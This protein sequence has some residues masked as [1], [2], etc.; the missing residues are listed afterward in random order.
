MKIGYQKND[1]FYTSLALKINAY[2]EQNGISKYANTRMVLK[3][4]FIATLFI[5][6]Y[7]LM[8]SN[9]FKN[10]SLFGLQILFHFSMFLMAVGIAHDGSHYAYSQKRWV[11]RTL[12]YVFDVIGINSHFWTYNHVHSHHAAPNVPILDSAIESF[13]AVRLHPKTKLN[14]LNKYQHL[15]MFLIYAFVPLFQIFLLEFVSFAKKVTGY[16]EKDNHSRGQIYFMC[17]SKIVF[18]SYSLIILLVV[19]HAPALH[20]VIGFLVGNMFIGILL[21]IIFQTTHICTHSIFPDPDE[22]GI[23]ETTYSKHIFLTTSEFAVENPLVTWI[24]GGLNLHATHHLFPHVSHIH[25]PAM[26]RIVRETAKEYNMP[27][28]SY[29]FWGAIFSHLKTL[30]KLGNAPSFDIN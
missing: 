23:M 17:I 6:S 8:L 20:I 7:T 2:F 12:T 19:I 24:A 4:L 25:L 10:W 29:S 1:A 16:S 5:G 3:S 9:H 30:K 13:S 18:L 22:N 27:Y 26:S 11:N 15:Y 14:K 28:K 21:G